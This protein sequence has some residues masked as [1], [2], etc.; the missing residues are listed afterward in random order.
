[1]TDPKLMP[2]PTPGPWRVERPRPD[3]LSRIGVSA[4]DGAVRIYDAPLTGE[5][6]ANAALIASAPTLKAD[7]AEAVALLREMEP[8]LLAF[9]QREPT[10]TATVRVTSGVLEDARA[11]LAR[12]NKEGK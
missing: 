6:E 11:F 4:C 5:T 12:Q 10:E 9:Y 1:M 7:L 8:L 3:Y 2:T